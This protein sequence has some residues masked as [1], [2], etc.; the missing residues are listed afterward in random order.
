MNIENDIIQEQSLAKQQEVICKSSVP[1]VKK[2]DPKEIKKIDA[3]A[4]R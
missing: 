4:K 1:S 2:I 3:E